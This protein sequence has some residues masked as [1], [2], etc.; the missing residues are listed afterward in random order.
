MEKGDALDPNELI[1]P[2]V[3][4]YH[5]AQRQIGWVKATELNCNDEMWVPANAVFH[6]YVPRMDM[7]LFRSNTN[8]LASGNDL[9][10]AVLHGLC[11]V[12][13]RDSWSICEGRRKVTGDIATPEKGPVKELMDMFTSKGIEVHL[14][15]LTSDLGVATVAAA[16]DDT[17]LQDPALL[18]LGIGAH[19]ES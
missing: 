11:E 2:R 12:I 6:P 19:L 5:L 15:D 17:Q 14:K 8:G 7:Q 16:A 10:E 13:E 18:T 1:L 4:A 3:P 9:E